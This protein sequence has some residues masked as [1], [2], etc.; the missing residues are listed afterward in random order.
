MKKL[1]LMWIML[2]GMGG[3]ISVNAVT[4]KATFDT[5]AANASWDEATNTYT[6]TASTNNLMTMF[7]FP[8]GELKMYSKIHLEVA[9]DSHQNFRFCLMNGGEPLGEVVCWSSGTKDITFSE[10]ANTKDVDL[11]QV[12]HIA[13]GGSANPAEGSYSCVL[14]N[15]YL[16]GPAAGYEA[17]YRAGTPLSLE[18]VVS[19][20]TLVSIGG[21]DNTILYGLCNDGSQFGSNQIK[22][23]SIRD[24]MDLI[25]GDDNTS[26][27]FR[28]TEATD[29]NLV[30]PEGITTLYRIKAFKKDG[31][32]PYIG[33]GWNGA[34]SFYLQEIS[35][36]YNV[37][38]G[39]SADEASFFA[40]TA[41]DGKENTY[42][43]SS[44]KIDGTKGHK[45]NIFDKSEWIFHELEENI[46][47]EK[48]IVESNDEI[49]AI[50]N[51]VD[52]KWTLDEP[53]NLYDWNYLV[54]ATENTA[55]NGSHRITLRDKNGTSIGGDDY[56]G[57]ALG[58][59]AGMWLD[60][61]NSQNIIAIDLNAVRIN[62]G[63]DIFNIA[64]LE[65]EG[66]IK[67]SV[68]YLTDYANPKI[69]NRGRW[70]LYV[71]G[72]LIRNYKQADLGKFGTIC[73]PYKASY[74]GAEI[75]S[76]VNKTSNSITLEKVTGLM[77]AGKPY[78]YKAVDAVGQD[79]R[80]DG[81]DVHNVHFF[82]AD[83][84]TYDVAEPIANNGL[85]GTFTAITAPQG[86][87]FY[88]LSGNKLY[89]TAGS[90][91]HVGANKAY[92]DMSQIVNQSSEAKNR[93]S[94]DF[95]N[96]EATGIESVNDTK[97]LN[98]GKMYDLSGREVTNPT[99][100]IYIM[101][102]K[103]IIIK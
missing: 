17:E 59:G 101:G 82:R 57:D 92:I 30:M 51:F 18:S 61:W 29:E 93:I 87:N 2:L 1:L 36:T 7:T 5:P 63:L 81:K 8:N 77:E 65:I 83:L 47:P 38:D 78:F 33:P 70:T 75:Y 26:Y 67:P 85:I 48:R 4:L 11:S 91:V 27:Q 73:L 79:N 3:V 43:I 99:S 16:E 90:E 22:L 56:K 98:S 20:N 31:T 24:A 14:T 86:E 97:V 9:Q 19:G 58:T 60:Y 6:W 96:A 89:D 23:T 35:W 40:I 46:V 50:N 34:N 84:D 10:H 53:T 69:T 28:I 25:S 94:I 66:D 88:V 76:I 100:G 103:K 44:Y 41:V 80:A 37:A 64:S 74:T 12:T 49:F 95:G 52:G 55:A 71:D 32:T 21:T 13:F 54:I 39:T 72:D 102:G 15:V 45:E 68:V 42:K 62:Y